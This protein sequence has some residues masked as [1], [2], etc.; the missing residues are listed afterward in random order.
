MKNAA[1]FSLFT[2][3]LLI[4]CSAASGGDRSKDDSVAQ[5]ASPEVWSSEDDAAIF[6]TPLERKLAALPTAGEA[7]TIPWAGNYWPTYEDNINH[8]WAGP[9]TDSPA[10]KYEK[11]FGGTNV[12]DAVSRN[13][14]IDSQNGKA[15]TKTSECDASL[16]EACAF[17][18]GATTGKCI[19]TW[20]GICHAW[21]PAAILLPEPKHEVV[22]NGVTFK[23]QDIKALASL[24][25]NRTTSKFVSLR[26]N[27][28][29]SAGQIKY[30]ASGR[31]VTA[32]RECKDT[33]AGTYHLLLANYLGKLKK[34]FVEDRTFDSEVWNQPLRGYKVLSTT[35]VTAGE[36]NALLGVAP[37][38]G[39]TVKKSGTV[40][41]GAWASQGGFAVTAGTTYR[42]KTTGTGDADLSVAF[43]K[44]PTATAFACHSE[45][46]TADEICEGTVPAGAKMLQVSMYGYT[47]ATFDVEVLTNAQLPTAYAFNASAASLV[48][49]KSDVQYIGESPASTDG[50]LASTIDRYTRT[51]HYDYVLELNLAGE[52]V[53]GEWIGASKKSHP[54]F[55]WLPTGVSGTTVA[56]GAISYAT[57]KALADESVST[58]TPPPGGSEKTVTETGTVVAKEMKTFGPYKAA[59]ASSVSVS[60]TGTGDADLY[61]RNGSAPTVSAYDCRPYT[62]GS[63]ESCTQTGAGDFFVSVYGYDATSNYTVTVKYVAA[64]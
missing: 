51:D 55:V 50:N 58:T 61:V 32:Q 64:P 19:A 53:G 26:C 16:G 22:K 3:V 12:E 8:R 29:E 36:A 37:T 23:V 60:M 43:D 25:H 52:I 6:G 42:V 47:A 49:V 45:G 24:V 33:N 7:S 27:L 20:F 11:A 30:D 46:N 2:P 34:S 63:T 62:S 35:A 15:C 44:E 57:V 18:T 40:A 31:P 13:H 59:A 54:D 5:V 39:T 48:R 1:I 38:G 9:S 28:N 56:G 21:S 14:G 17:R 4:A 41:K 10:K